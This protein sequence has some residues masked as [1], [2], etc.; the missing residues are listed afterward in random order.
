MLWPSAHRF[1]YTLMLR[2]IRVTT[3]F[4][5]GGRHN[6]TYWQHEFSRAWRVLA[7]ALGLPV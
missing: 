1:A 2:H 3:H 4:Y 7:P 6:W 5:S